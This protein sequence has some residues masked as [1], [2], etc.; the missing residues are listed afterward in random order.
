MSASCMSIHTFDCNVSQVA[1]TVTIKTL[2]LGNQYMVLLLPAK[3]RQRFQNKL[4]HNL[5]TLVTFMHPVESEVENIYN[6]HKIVQ[7][8]KS[9]GQ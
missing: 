8:I 7:K 5:C 3:L 2:V 6:K 4:L 1:Y 9:R